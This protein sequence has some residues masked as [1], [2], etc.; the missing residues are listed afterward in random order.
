MCECQTLLYITVSRQEKKSPCKHLQVHKIFP[1]QC[2]DIPTLI[3]KGPAKPTR[4]PFDFSCLCI[5][6]VIFPPD[7]EIYG[8]HTRLYSKVSSSWFTDIPTYLN[9]WALHWGILN[10]FQRETLLLQSHKKLWTSKHMG[11]FYP[12]YTELLP[13]KF[14]IVPILWYNSLTLFLPVTLSPPPVCFLSDSEAVL[15]FSA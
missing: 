14:S 4:S 1:Q 13:S 6:S 2:P 3:P 8:A 5:L 11:C 10:Q 12:F 9:L 15:S 7:H